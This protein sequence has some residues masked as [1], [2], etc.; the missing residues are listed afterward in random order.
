MARVIKGQV[1]N[2]KVTMPVNDAYDCFLRSR[3]CTK[4]SLMIYQDIGRRII[5]P[6]LS[7]LTDNNMYDITTDVLQAIIDNY[8]STHEKGGT[9]FLFRHLR[10]F[11]NWYWQEFE[12]A[13][14]NP[15]K[16][17]RWKT[18]STPP[19]K[20]ITQEEVELLIET[21]KNHSVFPERDIAMIMILCDTG[22][23]RSS[24]EG[25]RM[26][27]VDTLHSEMLVFEK[28]QKYHV[29]G[30]GATTCKAIRRYL[31]CLTDVSPDDPFW[32]QMD[33]KKLTRVGMREVLVRL[34]NEAK[35]PMHHFHDFRRYFGKTLYESTRDI[36][37]VSKA[38][39]H[40]DI[41]VTKRYIAVDEK[42][43]AE[44]VRKHSPMDRI[45]NQTNVKVK[46]V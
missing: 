9:D 32:L 30:F 38:L 26:K 13:T 19:K 33:G 11:I 35:I 3:N 17:V 18:P 40:K 2:S 1:T 23:R 8:E 25:L 27:D 44:S 34:C 46:R 14:K 22:I 43:N 15:M 21:A 5:V 7:E 41:Y 29:K 20:G 12:I 16:K 28:D 42:E 4:S 45:F 10:T 36:F 6:G 39:D 24:I 31:N 37:L